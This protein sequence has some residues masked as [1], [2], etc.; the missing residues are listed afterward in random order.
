MP[1][2]D[3][4][5]K[6]IIEVNQVRLED[7]HRYPEDFVERPPYQRKSVWSEERQQKLLDSLFRRYY[8]PPIVLREVRLSEDRTIREVVDGQQRIVT[9]RQF[10]GD[11]LALPGSLEDV[12]PGLAGRRYSELPPDMRR[13][14][15][16]KLQ[17]SVSLI[18]GI[19]DP[20]NPEHQ[21]IVADIFWRL[22]QGENLNYMEIAHSQVSSL[23][24][25][26][27]VKYADD[28]GFDYAAYK[29]LDHNPRKH[30]FFRIYDRD[31]GRMQHLSLFARLLLIELG[32]GP[33]ETRDAQVA[34]LFKDTQVPDGIG[35][36]S[37]ETNPAAK[38]LLRHLQAF[39]EI[40]KDDPMPDQ[41]NGMKEFRIEYFVISMYLLL[42]HLLKHYVFDDAEKTL[43]HDFVLEFHARWMQYQDTDT[44]VL[45][46]SNSRQQSKG[47]TE[48]RDRILRQLFFSYVSDHEHT[49]ITKDERRAFNEA[50]R[51]F[52]YRQAK[53]LCQQCLAEGRPEREAR[54]SW[55]DYEADHVIPHSKGGKTDLSNGQL[56]CR[57][58]NK[59]KSNQL[60]PNG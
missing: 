20:K 54:V 21:R 59:L 23:V 29:P 3:P 52:I 39:Y 42:R 46:F 33:A 10:Y 38:S 26:F 55:S 11:R 8:V 53:G 13:F 41:H 19:D 49:M 24:R 6:Y 31:N 35:N 40:F 1:A 9:A 5:Q 57:Y 43:F 22:Q 36:E 48:N 44:E 4:R 30:V 25:N 34:K 51:I 60:G 12:H 18:K 16:D 58:H 45:L 27:V 37:Y 32:N 15:D 2:F 47:E 7:F 56:L 17:Y 28:I 50:E 14:V